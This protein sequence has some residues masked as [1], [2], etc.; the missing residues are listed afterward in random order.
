MRQWLQTDVGRLQSIEPSIA[1]TVA[2]LRARAIAVD[3]D[4]R[5]THRFADDSQRF[6]H[7]TLSAWLAKL[8]ALEANESTAVARRLAW[9]ERIQFLTLAHRHAP[10]SWQ[11]AR[12]EIAKADGVT[13][14]T[15][16][17]EHPIDLSPQLGLVPIGMNPAT[18]L[19]EFYE[20]RS[21]WDPATPIDDAASL[22]I[23]VHDAQGNIAVGGDTGIVFVLLPGATSAMG[24]QDMP[25]RK[26]ENH[27]PGVLSEESPVHLVTL[28]PFFVARHELTQGSGGA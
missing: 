24:A 27:D 14:S 16:Y 15:L 17:Q 6:L 4:G 20:L 1:S 23:P 12:A 5:P 19:W 13:A 25:E 2:S 9:A 10:S 28:A 21:A 18:K 26:G 3:I 22:P 7:N 8:E 11:D